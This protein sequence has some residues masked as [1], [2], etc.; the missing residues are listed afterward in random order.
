MPTEPAPA[1]LSAMAMNCPSVPLA[2]V[3]RVD[4]VDGAVYVPAPEVEKFPAMNSMSQSPGWVAVA[5]GVGN[6]W[7]WELYSSG[8][9]ATSLGAASLPPEYAE[10]AQAMYSLPPE[11]IEQVTDRPASEDA[12]PTVP[13]ATMYHKDAEA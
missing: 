11:L 1:L 3:R 4:A 2:L 6:V 9:G 8:V 10:I 13:A 7:T 12:P 5:L